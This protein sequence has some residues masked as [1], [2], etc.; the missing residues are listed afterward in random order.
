M[1]KRLLWGIVLIAI[2]AMAIG[3]VNLLRARADRPIVH[4]DVS[5]GVIEGCLSIERRESGTIV[6]EK[7]GCKFLTNETLKGMATIAEI[8]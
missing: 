8:P 3:G 7:E 4:Y 2:F 5:R 1:A 6:I